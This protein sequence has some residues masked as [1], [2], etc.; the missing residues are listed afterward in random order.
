MT[1]RNTLNEHKDKEMKIRSIVG[2]VFGASPRCDIVDLISA[3]MKFC[4]TVQSL[5]PEVLTRRKYSP[6]SDF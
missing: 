1:Y 6:A 4:G 5:A 2:R 3:V